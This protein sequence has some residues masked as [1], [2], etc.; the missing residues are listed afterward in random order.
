[1]E[2]AIIIYDHKDE[3]EKNTLLTH[4]SILERDKKLKLWD[5]SHIL[6]GMETEAEIDQA[7]Y[8]AKLAI[9]LVTANFFHSNYILDNVLPSLLKQKS[10]HKLTIVPVIAKACYWQDVVW[11][12]D[13]E[14]L[15]DN[16]EP[17][18]GNNGSYVDEKLTT[19]VQKIAAVVTCNHS[20]NDLEDEDPFEP[21]TVFVPAGPF[22]VGTQ[23]ASDILSWETPQHEVTLPGYYIGKYPVTNEA[24]LK[25]VYDTREK[26]NSSYEWSGRFVPIEKLDH[27]AVKISWYHALAYCQWL[28]EQTGK[29][30]RLPTEIEWEKAARGSDG[31]TYPWGNTWD[32]KLCNC[33]TDQTASVR[34]FPDGA[35]VY[36]CYNMVGNIWEWTSTLWGQQWNKCDYVYPYQADDGREDLQAETNVYRVLRGGDYNDPLERLKITSRGCYYPDAAHKT[37]GFRVVLEE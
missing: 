12:R 14:V 23:P 37:I 33:F 25:F 6:A 24:Y 29:R 27:P 7:I 26:G 35:S 21:E 17:V 22:L 15:P 19:V 9:L 36:G 2:P 31:R 34:A 20:D 32:H 5:E 8:Q 18:W 10:L 16:G 1:M 28:S 11:L 3:E 30:Y 4:L 13:I